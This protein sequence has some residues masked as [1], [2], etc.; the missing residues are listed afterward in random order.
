[1]FQGKKLICFDLDGTLIDS[2]GIWNQVDAALIQQLSN[3]EV[4]LKTIQQQRD[5]QLK[6][7]RQ[8]ADPYLEY[9]GYLNE[10]YAFGLTKAQVKSRRYS[11]SHY[12]LDHVVPLKPQANLLIHTLKQREIKLAITTTTS[13]SNIQRYQDNNT[14]INSKIDFT[15][16]FSLILTREN[17]EN[18]KPHPEV[19][20]TALQHFGF[21]AEE[22]LIIEDSLI[23]VEAAKQ[24]GIE[25][26]AIYDQHSAHELEEIKAQAN[27]FVQDYAELLNSLNGIEKMP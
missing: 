22:C 18:I 26:I 25:V 24:A 15:N 27:Y 16:D 12:F 21:K 9:C 17:V 20:L 3:I 19:Y 5:I 11:I 13:L 14:L 1:M 8:S 2:V 7:F 4:D 23:G 10:F 6:I